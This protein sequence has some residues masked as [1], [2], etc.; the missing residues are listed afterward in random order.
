MCISYLAK[1]GHLQ[2]YYSPQGLVA[3][4]LGLPTLV[5]ARLSSSLMCEKGSHDK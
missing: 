5:V 1:Y 2:V 4:R 3:Q